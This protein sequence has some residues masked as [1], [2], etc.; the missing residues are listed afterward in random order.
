VALGHVFLGFEVDKVALGYVF[1]GYEVDKVALGHFL[2]YSRW[3]KWRWETFSQI[4][5]NDAP[6]S[7]GLLW[8]SDQYVAETST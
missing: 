5:H 2:R 3:K 1:L 6:Q 4:T 7:L 8:T